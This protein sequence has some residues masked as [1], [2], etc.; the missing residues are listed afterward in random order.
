MDYL[1][2]Q[3]YVPPT[4]WLRCVS[5]AVGK[6]KTPPRTRFVLGSRL[7]GI[8][9]HDAGAAAEDHVFKHYQQAER[10][11]WEWRG[12]L[13]LNLKAPPHPLCDKPL[14]A[15][16]HLLTVPKTRNQVFK[17]SWFTGNISLIPP[18]W[19]ILRIEEVWDRPSATTGLS[20]V[21][22]VPFLPLRH[23][24]PTHGYSISY[25]EVISCSFS[26]TLF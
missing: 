16:P 1:Y 7:W 13:F 18:Q 10:T 22:W 5:I 4:E 25:P 26:L 6:Q 17:C 15:K 8:R 24:E 19:P 2:I 21:Q 3:S 23:L 11:N 9:V 20:G 14:S 12:A